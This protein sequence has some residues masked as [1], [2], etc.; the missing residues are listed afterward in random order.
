MDQR[1]VAPVYKDIK[2]FIRY[3]ELFDEWINGWVEVDYSD[4]TDKDVV[5][6]ISEVKDIYSPH[7][8]MEPSSNYI[9]GSYTFSVYAKAAE[10]K[11][12]KL[13]SSKY[14]IY[15]VHTV[16]DLENGT[17]ADGEGWIEDEGNGWY[18]CAVTSQIT[19]PGPFNLA[20]CILNDNMEEEYVG[21]KNKGIYL[22]GAQFEES[23]TPNPDTPPT[24]YS[25]TYG[26]P[27]DE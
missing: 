12:M 7:C 10:R 13:I 4:E 11:Y 6:Y 23:D 17:I 22:F 16:F 14:N 19:S 26:Y 2:N 8:V 3:S 20:I 1:G 5:S 25:K 27:S 15:D 18:R 21:E 24:E 9:N